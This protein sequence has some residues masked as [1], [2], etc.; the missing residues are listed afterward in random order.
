MVCTMVPTLRMVKLQ[1][2]AACQC[3][4]KRV[5]SIWYI[6][7]VGEV[8][9]SQFSVSFQASFR[10]ALANSAQARPTVDSCTS[11]RGYSELHIAH[12]AKA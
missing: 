1:G 5:Y 3:R 10:Q 2:N 9:A 6:L 11:P 7:G 4:G 8:E 12:L